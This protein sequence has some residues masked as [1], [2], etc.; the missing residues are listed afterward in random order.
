VTCAWQVVEYYQSVGVRPVRRDMC[1]RRTRKCSRARTDTTASRCSSSSARADAC[2]SDVGGR[3]G[4][5]SAAVPSTHCR[6]TATGQLLT[7]VIIIIVKHV[8]SVLQ[9]AA[10]MSGGPPPPAYATVADVELDDRSSDDEVGVARPPP[11]APGAYP[12]LYE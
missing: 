8:N 3:D 9:N 11:V 5:V 2:A 1:V 12:D 6:R 7:F 4:V 10:S